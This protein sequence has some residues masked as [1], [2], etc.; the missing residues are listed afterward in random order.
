MNQLQLGNKSLERQLMLLR[1]QLGREKQ[2]HEFSKQLQRELGLTQQE[3]GRLREDNLIL[4]DKIE[5]LTD[6]LGA[7]NNQILELRAEVLYQKQQKDESEDNMNNLKKLVLE[8]KERGVAYVP[9]S[10]DLIDQKLANFINSKTDSDKYK[11]LF[12]RE[13]EGVYTFGSKKIFVKIEQDKILIRSGGGYISVE[14]FLNLY[15]QREMDEIQRKDPLAAITKNK[16]VSR[17]MDT[18]KMSNKFS[19]QS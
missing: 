13:G 1:E 18:M 16:A 10:N 11:A 7:S 9:Q 2:E 12:V 15:S 5:E 3:L 6:S 19:P 8:M 17:K 14:E 4:T